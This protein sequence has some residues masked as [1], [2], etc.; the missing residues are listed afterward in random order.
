MFCPDCGRPYDAVDNFCRFCGHPLRSRLSLLLSPRLLPQVWRETR[1][2]LWRGLAALAVGTTLELVRRE[3]A[4]RLSLPAKPWKAA[5]RRSRK[6][7]PPES[8]GDGH[9]YKV[10][11][12]VGY[13]RF[14]R[15]F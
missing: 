9:S 2:N 3:A 12:L 6:T 8:D 4:R 5:A 15:R 10:E 14:W 13:R 1:S 7:A 11:E